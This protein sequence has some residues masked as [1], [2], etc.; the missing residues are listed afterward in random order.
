[1]IRKVYMNGQVSTLLVFEDHNEDTGFNPILEA[2]REQA[3]R[4]ESLEEQNRELVKQEELLASLM[5]MTAQTGELMSRSLKAL[6]RLEDS[7][8]IEDL[9]EASSEV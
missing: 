7:I 4:I 9:P 1:M 2:L 5:E 8:E 3:E 6:E